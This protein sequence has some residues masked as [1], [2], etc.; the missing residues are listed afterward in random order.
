M[1]AAGAYLVATQLAFETGTVVS[2][3]YPFGALVLA[4]VGSI[5]A[6]YLLAAFERERVR[7]V[8]SR[9][10]PDTVVDQVLARTDGDLR[11]GGVELVGTA[12]FTDLRG[13]TSFAESLPA[14]QVID[15]LNVYLSEMSDA[16]LAHGGTLVAY[17]GDGIFAVFGAPIEQA[18]H[19]DRALAAAREM[20]D[21]RLPRFN[22]FVL[23]EHGNDGFRMG[24]G[25]NSGPFLSGQRRLRAPAR[26]HG[27]R[28]HDEHGARLEGM[29]KGTSYQ[30]YV[31]DTTRQALTA[32]GRGSRLRRRGRD[33]RTQE[34]GAAVGAARSRRRGRRGARG[35]RPGIGATLT[36]P[37]GA[38]V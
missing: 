28:R 8:F 11:L 25:L 4:T 29:T 13:F 9:F 37:F 16:I 10:V 33:P 17:M 23:R 38:F 2:F 21:E 5:G 34:H 12:M 32:R 19:A 26:V 7:G 35:C 18:D 24:I 27:D 20:L 6:H 31:A 22:A 14:R 3:V 1:A 15:I 36:P 30:C